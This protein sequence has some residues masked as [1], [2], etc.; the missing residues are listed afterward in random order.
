MTELLQAL[1]LLLAMGLCVYAPKALP[2]VFVSLGGGRHSRALR[3]WLEYVS[4]AVL[5][6]LVAAEIAAPRGALTPPRP[7]HLA[8]AAV[9]ALA[10][11]TRRVWLSLAAGLGLFLLLHG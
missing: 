9:V 10:A 8:Y 7:E 11:L 6:A 3:T 4:P 2:L 1:P 5:S